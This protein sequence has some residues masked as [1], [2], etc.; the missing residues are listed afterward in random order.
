V[1][2]EATIHPDVYGKLRARVAPLG[3]VARPKSTP[4]PAPSVPEIALLRLLG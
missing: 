1:R 4:P 2:G 3:A